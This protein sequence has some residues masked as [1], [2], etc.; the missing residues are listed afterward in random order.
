MYCLYS[1]GLGD[2]LR[3]VNVAFD[4]ELK[5]E[6]TRKTFDVTDKMRSDIQSTAGV[7]LVT[8]K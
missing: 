3:S 8:D 5:I 1:N 4:P 7:S 2:L 6:A